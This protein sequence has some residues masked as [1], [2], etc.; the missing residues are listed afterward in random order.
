MSKK[1]RNA[2]SKAATGNKNVASK[3]TISENVKAEVEEVKA[4]EIK[5]EVEEVKAEEIKAEVEEAKAEEAKA[6]ETKVEEAKAE[7]TK[8]E[9]VKTEEVKTEVVKTEK[10]K[11]SKLGI[12]NVVLS[13]ITLASLAAVIGLSVTVMDKNK[14]QDE[15]VKKYIEEQYEEKAKA[16]EQTSTYIEDGYKIGDSYEIK[17]TKA[18]S[19]AYI[20]GNTEGLSAED[21]DT[22]DMAKAVL[23]EV[24]KDGMTDYEK[25]KAL[26]DWL[27][28][29]V[30]GDNSNTV[31][32]MP[33]TSAGDTFTPHGVLS[34]K[35]AVCVG[36]ATTFRLLVNM[37]GMDCHIVHNE[38]HSWDIVKIEDEWYQ[39]DI[40]SAHNQKGEGRY[41][42]FNLTDAEMMTLNQWSSDSLPNAKGKKYSYAC[43]NKVEANSIMDVPKIVKDNL[44]NKK[45]VSYISFKNQLTEEDINIANEIISQ[46]TYAAD[47]GAFAEDFV[48]MD[49]NSTND[50]SKQTQVTATEE[51]EFTEEGTSG[52]ELF[53]VTGRWYDDGN[54]S[55]ILGVLIEKSSDVESNIAIDDKKR[56]EIKN[57]MQSIF[58]LDM[59]GYLFNPDTVE[60]PQDKE[61]NQ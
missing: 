46:I 45:Y 18:I 52:E 59:S 60:D 58:G 24:I 47:M 29:N 57:L 13:S 2:N 22:L 39:L 35:Q 44:K 41:A 1:N 48:P 12:A 4:E 49:A 32:A 27:C 54:G 34:S 14:K 55:Y 61:C 3:E 25:E 11:A 51:T 31:I 17:S 38:F 30:G 9:E 20:S 37:L 56:E 8:A 21:K 40:Y 23:D 26:F 15:F 28:D 19:D 10:K 16:L 5:A 42:F 33:G 43:M 50:T 36:Y 6:E 7:E 53:Y